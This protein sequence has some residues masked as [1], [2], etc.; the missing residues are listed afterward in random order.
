[1]VVLLSRKGYAIYKL[2]KQQK[3]INVILFAYENWGT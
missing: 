2:H 1:M 3:Y